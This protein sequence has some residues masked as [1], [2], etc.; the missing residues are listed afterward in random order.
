MKNRN[1]PIT[2]SRIYIRESRTKMKKYVR[3][4]V[5]EDKKS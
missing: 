4:T 5:D 2:N 3:R 1:S